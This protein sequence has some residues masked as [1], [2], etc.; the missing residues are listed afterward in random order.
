MHNLPGDQFAGSARTTPGGR[1]TM[2][3]LAP[4]LIEVKDDKKQTQDLWK[5]YSDQTLHSVLLDYYRSNLRNYQSSLGKDKRMFMVAAMYKGT[6]T[7]V[8]G[9]Y[10]TG[11]YGF[12]SD[13]YNTTRKKVAHKRQVDEADMMSFNFS[14]Y[15]PR[16]TSAG[17]R[18]RGLMLLSRFNTLGIRQLTIPHLRQY[19]ANRFPTFTLEV[20]RVVPKIVMETILSQGSLKTIRL[21]KKS[22][23]SDI[24]DALSQ[25]DRENV[26]DIELVIHSKRRSF[27]SDV[28]WLIR[29]V[30]NNTR[31]SEIIT[32][33]SFEHDNIKLEIEMDG[34]MRTVDLGNT[35]KL[36]SNIEIANITLGPDGR[37]TLID[38]LREAYDLA[39]GIAKS[40]GMSGQ[41]WAS[42]AAPLG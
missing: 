8:C 11:Q 13:I 34:K 36:S 1:Q 23:P 2:F 38:W 24:A 29:A 28:D 30:E 26:Q 20:S 25:S 33:P 3:A 14:F 18:K 35:A 6:P 21:I 40:W 27:F 22:L 19:F 16:V 41:K 4:Y 15:L 9:T 37:P 7:S 10:Q 32:I 31:P 5:F 12:E 39:G 17:Q 42:D